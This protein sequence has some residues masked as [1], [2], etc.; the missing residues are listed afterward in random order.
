MK[1]TTIKNSKLSHNKS[2]S[3][4]HESEQDPTSLRVVVRKKELAYAYWQD[5]GNKA[6][7]NQNNSISNTM[8][9]SIPNYMVAVY[10]DQNTQ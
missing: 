1:N 3:K 2:N 9:C 8:T 10:Q 7:T 5:T 6:L 4:T